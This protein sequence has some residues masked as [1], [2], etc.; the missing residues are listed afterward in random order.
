M[1]QREIPPGTRMF[2]GA[3]A[4]PMPESKVVAIRDAV[5]GIDG[6]LEAHLPQCF[7]EGDAQA[8]QVLVIG[9]RTKGEIPRI[10]NELTP[11]LSRILGDGL[12][13]DLLPFE[14]AAIPEGVRRAR[15]QLFGPAT[16]PWWKVW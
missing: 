14:A 4:N 6:I 10:A 2:F 11:G 15:C 9:V 13:L 5:R 1:R 8:H 16:K 3:P 7:I 12:F